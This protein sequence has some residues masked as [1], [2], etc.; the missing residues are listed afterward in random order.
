[1]YIMYAY[2]CIC[3]CKDVYNIHMRTYVHTYIIHAHI[4][5]NIICMHVCMRVYYVCMYSCMAV[6]MYMYIRMYVLIEMIMVVGKLSRREYI[7]LK[8]GEKYSPGGICPGGKSPEEKCPVET[9]RFPAHC[10]CMQGSISH[11]A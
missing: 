4:Y 11:M 3:A 5:T 8:T 7:L 10:I 1:M 6:C 2:V 9:V